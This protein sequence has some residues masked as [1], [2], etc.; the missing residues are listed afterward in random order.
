MVGQQRHKEGAYLTSHIAVLKVFLAVA[1]FPKIMALPE[2]FF[3]SSK[4][5]STASIRW[6]VLITSSALHL[7]S[8]H[9]NFSRSTDL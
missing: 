9:E 4:D 1:K 6:V 5:L 8:T 3:C 7:A 2:V